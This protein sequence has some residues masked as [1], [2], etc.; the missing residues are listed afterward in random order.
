M[1]LFHI[2]EIVQ[3][4]PNRAT[5]HICHDIVSTYFLI[6]IYSWWY[7]TQSNLSQSQN[8]F[9]FSILQ[10]GKAFLLQ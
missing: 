5:H 4:V 3:M 6:F 10:I 2:F 8:L 7:V 1:G 9:Y